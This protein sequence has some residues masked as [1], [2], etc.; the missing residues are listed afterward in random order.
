MHMRS[1]RLF[2]ITLFTCIMRSVHTVYTLYAAIAYLNCAR[3][4]SETVPHFAIHVHTHCL[5]KLC[6]QTVGDTNMGGTNVS[7]VVFVA[8]RQRMR[9]ATSVCD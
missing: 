4:Q 5:P 8:C 7:S 3:A 2:L 9:M 6:T 1:L